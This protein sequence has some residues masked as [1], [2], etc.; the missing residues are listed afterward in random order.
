MRADG[1]EDM[2]YGDGA[3]SSMVERQTTDAQRRQTVNAPCRFCG[4]MGRDPWGA[5]CPVCGGKGYKRLCRPIAR[6]PVCGGKGQE[7]GT[8][9]TCTICSGTGVVQ[10]HA[11]YVPCPDCSGS[12]RKYD[13]KLSCTRCGGKGRIRPYRSEPDDP[14][15]SA[16]QGSES[17][18]T[19]RVGRGRWREVTLEY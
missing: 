11:D 3:R 15:H 17:S 9:R 4:G 8:R 13:S 18:Y 14:P 10:V 5:L 19:R 16:R 7:P 6:C 2:R 1:E 12:G